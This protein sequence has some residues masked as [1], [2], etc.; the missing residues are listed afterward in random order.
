MGGERLFFSTT[1]EDEERDILFIVRLPDP[2]MLAL[3][4][5]QAMW[6]RCVGKGSRLDEEFVPYCLDG[7]D[8]VALHDKRVEQFNKE[9]AGIR[10]PV[11]SAGQVVGW[12][13]WNSDDRWPKTK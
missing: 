13:R 10:R 9:S 1:D 7:G 4:E 3:E 11:T 6:D 12:C 5:V 2:E 8:A